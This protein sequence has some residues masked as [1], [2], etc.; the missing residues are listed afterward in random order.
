[1]ISTHDVQIHHNVLAAT[2]PESLKSI[3]NKALEVDARIAK[4]EYVSTEE[5]SIILLEFLD[6]VTNYIQSEAENIENQLYTEKELK[7]RLN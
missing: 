7:K 5:R 3:F 4:G 1:M 2:I 6:E